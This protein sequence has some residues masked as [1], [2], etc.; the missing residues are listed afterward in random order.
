M[1]NTLLE[2]SKVSFREEFSSQI[3]NSYDVRSK[4]NG[5]L[6]ICRIYLK[7]FMIFSDL[8]MF[9]MCCFDFTKLLGTQTCSQFSDSYRAYVS[10]CMRARTRAWRRCT[11]RLPS[12]SRTYAVGSVHARGKQSPSSTT[13]SPTISSFFSRARTFRPSGAWPSATSDTGRTVHGQP[14]VGPSSP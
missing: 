2:I 10:T 1:S 5:L 6:I 3:Y 12:G 4:Q 9:Y 14:R 7:S 13:V 11:P 8:Y